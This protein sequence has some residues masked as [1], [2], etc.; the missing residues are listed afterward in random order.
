MALCLSRGGYRAMI[1]H[2]GSMWRM[3]E[4]GYLPRLDFISG[5]SGV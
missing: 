5:V 4:L 1:F 3:N 2:V